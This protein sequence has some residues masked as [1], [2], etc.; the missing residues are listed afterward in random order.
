LVKALATSKVPN[1]RKIGMK[2]RS[3]TKAERPSKALRP[4]LIAYQIS[5]DDFAPIRPARFER[6][7]MDDAEGKFPY[8]CLPLVIA[9]QYGWEILSTHHIRVRWDG[10]SAPEGL[11][12]ENLS[13]DGLLHAHSHFGQGVITFQIPFLF[14]TPAGWN[15]M[16]RG[17]INNPKDG[18]AAL[19]GIVETDWSHA[20]F[21]MNWR[22]T[23]ACTV[24]FVVGEPVCHFFPIPRGV[25]E[26]F[27]S[28]FRMLESEP[29]LDDKFQDWS[30]G[31]D[32]FLWAL[33]KRKPKVVAQGWQKEYLRTAKE[34]KSLAHPFVD[35]RSRDEQSDGNH[36]GR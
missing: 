1:D 24:E 20:T 10:T 14:R 30:D 34:K 26:E 13:G 7:W 4:K 27:R 8:R 11:V 21:T 3:V 31:R 17:P 6:K 33:G 35:E 18:I 23:R 29:K 22:F 36:D 2:T 32:W 25:L 19:D 28:E 15:L 12:I 16:V 5:E 9:N